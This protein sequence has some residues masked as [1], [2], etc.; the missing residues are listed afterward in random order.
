MS[1]LL[2]L[3]NDGAAH[4]QMGHW[5]VLFDLASPI[6]ISLDESWVEISG[7]ADAISSSTS[8]R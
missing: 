1:G 6:R 7:P 8:S 4:L 5:S 3:A 2:H